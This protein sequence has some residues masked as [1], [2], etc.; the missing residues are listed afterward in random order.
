MKT[1]KNHIFKDVTIGQHY[2]LDFGISYHEF[3]AKELKDN[4]RA[5]MHGHARFIKFNTEDFN[6]GIAEGKYIF[7]NKPK[8]F[9]YQT[10]K[11]QQ[12]ENSTKKLHSF[13]TIKASPKSNRCIRYDC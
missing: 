8:R 13:K 4:L 2:R 3:H 9:N 12:H 7:I 10:I 1:Y 11:L 6:K 5:K